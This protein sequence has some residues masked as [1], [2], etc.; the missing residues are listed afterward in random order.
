MLTFTLVES[1]LC[2]VSAS[3]AGLFKTKQMAF[4]ETVKVFPHGPC[5][6]EATVGCRSSNCNFH[7]KS[8]LTERNVPTPLL[9]S[10][11]A[12]FRSALYQVSLLM[13]QKK[14]E[15]R[16]EKGSWMRK[17]RKM[18]MIESPPEAKM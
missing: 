8:I 13:F 16:R 4:G 14:N 1:H 10:S 3:V 17:A 12:S 6:K 18:K 5:S 2:V 7:F 9:Y 11:P 15:G